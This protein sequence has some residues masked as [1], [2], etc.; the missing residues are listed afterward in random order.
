MAETT[1]ISRVEL[2]KRIEELERFI[3]TDKN[4]YLLIKEFFPDSRIKNT[5]RNKDYQL[6]CKVINKEYAISEVSIWRILKIKEKD[7]NTYQELKTSQDSIKQAYERLYNKESKKP[8]KIETSLLSEIINFSLIQANLEAILSNLDNGQLP[9]DI[10]LK[11]LQEID[12]DIFKL[13]KALG[14]IISREIQ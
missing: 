11:Q 3:N 6:I 10:N 13:R 5:K 8:V 7:I 14:K 9:K 12:T 2:F 4:R 1:K